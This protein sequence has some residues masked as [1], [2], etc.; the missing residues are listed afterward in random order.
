MVSKACKTCNR[1]TEKNVCPNCS[2]TNL[3]NRYQGV[4]III[5]PNKSEIAKKMQVN[6]PGEYAL[7][8]L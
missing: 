1:I 5:D 2:S 8:V 3:S 4:V 7:E 6:L